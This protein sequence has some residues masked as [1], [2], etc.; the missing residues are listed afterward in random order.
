MIT[1]QL[2]GLSF[3]VNGFGEFRPNDFIA[4]SAWIHQM[5]EMLGYDDSGE[6]FGSRYLN[7]L[8]ADGVRLRSR[9][10]RYYRRYAGKPYAPRRP[11]PAP[12]KRTR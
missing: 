12:A 8:D 7:S 11:R 2:A 5:A 3:K 4:G 9:F 6:G 1:G 10:L